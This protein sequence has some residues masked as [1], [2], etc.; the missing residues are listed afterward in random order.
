MHIL[1]VLFNHWEHISKA[2]SGNQM[3]VQTMVFVTIPPLYGT[4]NFI[5]DIETDQV[6]AKCMVCTE[7]HH[8]QARGLTLTQYFTLPLVF[9]M[10]ST[11]NARTPYG[12]HAECSE[13]VRNLYGIFFCSPFL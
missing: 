12:F 4:T 6:G 10:E 2:V 9:C 8:F 13:S 11:W 5:K 3:Q 1:P 7:R